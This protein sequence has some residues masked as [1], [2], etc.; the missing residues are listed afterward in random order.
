[1]M[2]SKFGICEANPNTADAGPEPR[3]HEITGRAPGERARV[4]VVSRLDED[5]IALLR[6]FL[7]TRWAVC[8][9]NNF[10]DAVAALHDEN[11]QVAICDRELEDGNWRAL[12]EVIGSMPTPPRMILTSRVADD[13]VWLQALSAGVY[14]VLAKPFN[15]NE[16]IR[17]VSDATRFWHT[18]WAMSN[19][20]RLARS[21]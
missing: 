4:L 3:H 9:W 17:V 7:H 20:L 12:L 13:L 19:R 11:I 16:V 10:D 21:A 5:L 15:E 1:M 6:I 14:D 2:S 18:D 8:W